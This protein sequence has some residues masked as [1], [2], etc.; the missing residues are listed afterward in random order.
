MELKLIKTLPT[1]LKNKAIEKAVSSF[2]EEMGVHF[3]NNVDISDLQKRS[4]GV[5]PDGVFNQTIEEIAGSL[6]FNNPTIDYW[7]ADVDGEVKGYVLA[8]IV[9][10]IDNRLCYWI[11]Q[12]WLDKEYRNNGFSKEC[13]EKLQQ[14]AQATMCKHIVIVS[15]RNNDAYMRFLAKGAHEYATL[16]KIDLED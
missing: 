5:K 15:V 3:L 1:N 10:D 13:W 16:L 11:S 7:M 2:I 9:K 12:A 14:R 8:T 4:N 6:I